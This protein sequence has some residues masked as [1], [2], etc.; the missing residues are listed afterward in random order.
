MATTMQTW[1]KDRGYVYPH[2]TKIPGVCGGRP[3]IDGTRVRVVN[4]VFLQKEGYTP[5]Q[6]LK[7]YPDLNLAQVHAALTY[8]YDHKDEIEAI[9]EA[10]RQ[11]F[12]NMHQEWEDY[13]ERHGGNPPE[14]PAPKDRHISKPAD[15][16]P[17]R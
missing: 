3:A 15:W 17:K 12:E 2:I 7:E 13:A 16:K 6:M 1:D 4:I 5:E 9:I 14:V 11:A 10:D 8:Y